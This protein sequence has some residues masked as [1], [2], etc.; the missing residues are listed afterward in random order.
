MVVTANEVLEHLAAKRIVPNVDAG[1]ALLAAFS[2]SIRDALQR[3]RVGPGGVPLPDHGTAV[4]LMRVVTFIRLPPQPSASAAVHY[5]FDVIFDAQWQEARGLRQARNSLPAPACP[6]RVELTGREA[7][8]SLGRLFSTPEAVKAAFLAVLDAFASLVQKDGS[9]RGGLLLPTLGTVTIDGRSLRFEYAEDIDRVVHSVARRPGSAAS[10]AS[11][12]PLTA[13]STVAGD[14]HYATDYDASR[15]AS[16]QSS[17]P[18]A[19][20]GASA[21]IKGLKQPFVPAAAT[22]N[23]SGSIAR[24]RPMSAA[25]RP[26]L[27]SDRAATAANWTS[28][29]GA[30][31]R[32][33][34]PRMTWPLPEADD[35]E[36]FS[37]PHSGTAAASGRSHT[38]QSQQR[39]AFRTPDPTAL[40]RVMERAVEAEMQ[41][42]EQR[43]EQEARQAARRGFTNEMSTVV[44]RATVKEQR[45]RLLDRR[46]ELQRQA[47]EKRLRDAAAKA[48][49]LARMPEIFPFSDQEDHRAKS[50]RLAR[51]QFNV[52]HK[53]SEERRSTSRQELRRSWADGAESVARARSEAAREFLDT[54]AARRQRREDLQTAWGAQLAMKYT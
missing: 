13:T 45:S 7:Q 37:L 49:A 48:D 50:R 12:S 19:S 39:S 26:P 3:V 51:E 40:Q 28:S 38:P 24:A 46:L 15:P 14:E 34:V 23:T 29:S 53:A 54:M 1:V 18:F 17:R 9:Q 25:G 35:Y 21:A 36:G 2:S 20:G 44:E 47:E 22:A 6:R 4:V 42:R 30:A 10:G 32:V 31:P 8:L 41:A 33:G 11:P 43:Y 16:A 52:N 27:P 5:K